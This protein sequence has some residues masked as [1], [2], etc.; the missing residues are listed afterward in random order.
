[1]PNYP[2]PFNPTTTIRLHLESASQVRLF[3]VGLAGET[4]SVLAEGVLSAGVHQYAWDATG[5][6]SGVYFC[7]MESVPTVGQ[8]STTRTRRMLL[9]R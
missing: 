8:S 5:R 4:V 3:V 6:P 9:L 1:L 7:R 2:N